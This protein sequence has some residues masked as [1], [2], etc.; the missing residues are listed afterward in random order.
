[1]SVRLLDLKCKGG[2]K[3]EKGSSI[4]MVAVLYIPILPSFRKSLVSINVSWVICLTR[5]RGGTFEKKSSNF[6]VVVLYIHCLALE[7]V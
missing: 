4:F 5:N 1:M 3:F 7:T 2:E 6:M